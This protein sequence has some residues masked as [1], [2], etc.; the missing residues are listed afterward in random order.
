MSNTHGDS[1]FVETA[2]TPEEVAHGG[3]AFGAGAEACLFLNG[4]RPV[5]QHPGTPGREQRDNPEN[6]TELVLVERNWTKF[7]ARND[8]EELAPL[9]QELFLKDAMRR[10]G[11]TKDELAQRISVTR[12]CLVKWMARYG[13]SEFRIMPKMAWKFIGEIMERAFPF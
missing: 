7:V 4:A 5:V 11:M 6:E 10:L 3:S 9:A 2:F 8:F 12:K 1:E 13:S